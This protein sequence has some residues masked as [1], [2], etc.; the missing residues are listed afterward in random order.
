MNEFVPGKAI[1]A[2]HVTPHKGKANEACRRV[3]KFVLKAPRRHEL[4]VHTTH[5]TETPHPGQGIESHICVEGSHKAN[6][7][8]KC[9]LAIS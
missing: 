1:D 2:S 5:Y 7:F 4:R 9:L 8:L 3:G 6:V